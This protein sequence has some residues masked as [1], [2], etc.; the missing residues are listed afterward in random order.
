MR[1]IAVSRIVPK[2]TVQRLIMSMFVSQEHYD[3]FNEVLKA[4]VK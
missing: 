1:Y 2:F 3:M 4:A